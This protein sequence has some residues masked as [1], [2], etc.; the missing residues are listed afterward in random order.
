MATTNVICINKINKHNTTTTQEEGKKGDRGK[1]RKVSVWFYTLLTLF[2]FLKV[3]GSVSLVFETRVPNPAGHCGLD[4]AA[5]QPS[6]PWVAELGTTLQGQQTHLK[7]V[8]TLMP[9]RYVST[10]PHI[11]THI[12]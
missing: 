6:S 10:H 3:W 7:G 4:K 12:H 11:H 1:G 9:Q 5:H 2:L 8:G